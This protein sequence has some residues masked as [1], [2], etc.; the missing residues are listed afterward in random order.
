MTP[1]PWPPGAVSTNVD[2]RQGIYSTAGI[3]LCALLLPNGQARTCPDGDAS[4]P[5]LAKVYAFTCVRDDTVITCV[6][7]LGDAIRYQPGP[8]SAR[9]AIEETIRASKSQA[10]IAEPDFA[11]VRVAATDRHYASRQNL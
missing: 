9:L 2:T 8:L 1:K 6:N 4:L 7:Q 11:L 5:G 3:A 10:A